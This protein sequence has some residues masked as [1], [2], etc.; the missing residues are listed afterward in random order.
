[1]IDASA[2]LAIMLD[3][4]DARK[5]VRE[6]AGIPQPFTTPAAVAEVALRLLNLLDAP[7]GGI[8]RDIALV[9]ARLRVRV[10]G[11][12]AECWPLAVDAARRFGKGRHPAALN[13]GDC[14]AYAAAR[15]AGVRLIY[16]GDDFSLTDVN[17]AF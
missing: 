5:W 12:S 15:E 9:L 8:E 7:A 2:I 16:K 17:A 11:L 10:H 6:I 13:F 1:M 3:E 14:L 4:P